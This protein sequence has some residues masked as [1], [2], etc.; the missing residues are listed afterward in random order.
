M[1]TIDL[2]KFR[3]KLSVYDASCPFCREK[4]GMFCSGRCPACL[5]IGKLE[6][7][8]VKRKDGQG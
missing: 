8:P 6:I 4:Q 2:G 5:S 7:A 3:S 1:N